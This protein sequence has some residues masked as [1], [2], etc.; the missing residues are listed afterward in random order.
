M[1]LG[2]RLRP[3]RR[4]TIKMKTTTFGRDHVWPR[5]RDRWN[6]KI[7]PKL[8]L[9]HPIFS[10]PFTT[11]QWP[12]PVQ[13]RDMW[14]ENWIKRES[15][16][17]FCPHSVCEKGPGSW[18]GIVTLLE[19]ACGH[20]LYIIQAPAWP[21]GPRALTN[22]RLGITQTD[23]SEARAYPS[24]SIHILNMLIHILKLNLVEN[25]PACIPSRYPIWYLRQLHLKHTLLITESWYFL[26]NGYALRT[27]DLKLPICFYF[28]IMLAWQRVQHSWNDFEQFHFICSY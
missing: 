21:R 27:F 13:C 2:Q 9:S 1:G 5:S 18:P 6:C 4:S 11:K 12:T 8:H 19:R 3:D 16:I 7:C 17:S 26:D 24:V 14:V 20:T 23:Q 28:L 10:H 22:Q 25:I 15:N